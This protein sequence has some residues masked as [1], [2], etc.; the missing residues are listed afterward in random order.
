MIIYIGFSVIILLTYYSVPDN[1][2]E[3]KVETMF[4]PFKRKEGHIQRTVSKK[5]VNRF[6]KTGLQIMAAK[7]KVY[8][9]QT[10]TFATPVYDARLAKAIFNKYMKAVMKKYKV[11]GLVALHVQERRNDGSQHF[12][13][14][15]LIFALHRLPFEPSRLYRDF[16]TD[17]YR[18]WHNLNDGET[19]HKANRLIPH[20]FNFET[21]YYFCQALEVSENPPERAETN[22]WGLW[23]KKLV[24]NSGFKPSKTEVE[25]W[26]N[27]MFKK[28]KRCSKTQF[29]LE[30]WIGTTTAIIPKQLGDYSGSHFNRP[31]L[32]RPNHSPL[33]PE[34]AED[35]DDMSI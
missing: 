26:F 19:V 16:R 10:L 25:Q 1:I 8:F 21:I 11:N 35:W 7:P 17:S 6:L 22:W 29:N 28:S 27:E 14:C 4:I 2:I 18:M 31:L 24:Y 34:H 15:F 9:H 30:D 32:H 5:S 12:H 20:E 13:V 3:W 33:Q 23:N